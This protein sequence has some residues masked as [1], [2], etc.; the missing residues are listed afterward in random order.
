MSNRWSVRTRLTLQSVAVTAFVLFALNSVVY[1]R[2]RADLYRRIDQNLALRAEKLAGLVASGRTESVLA[3]R[4]LIQTLTIPLRPRVFDPERRSVTQFRGDYPFDPSAISRSLAGETV[5]TTCPWNAEEVRVVSRPLRRNDG[6]ITRAAQFAAPLTDTQQALNTLRWTLFAMIPLGLLASGGAGLFLTNRALQPV[7]QVTEAT[8][9]MSAAD[10]SERLPVVGSD[11]FAQ[12]SET[13]NGM[14]TRLE[15]T[16]VRQHQFTGDASH[17]LRT[18]LTIIT[19]NAKLT[20]KGERSP[21]EYRRALTA[22]EGAAQTMR[23]LVDDLLTLA[24]ADSGQ[25][26]QDKC[27]ID[28]GPL[29]Q[30]TVETMNGLADRAPIHVETSEKLFLLA[31]EDEIRRLFT[32]LLDNAGRHTPRTGRILLSAHATGGTIRVKVTDNGCGIAAEHLPHLFERFYRVDAARTG[33]QGTGI[34]LAICRSIVTAHQGE[35]AIE[36]D[37]AKGT[38]VTI[39][40][41]A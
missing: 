38:T 30:S 18:P 3:E 39:D 8:A 33:G 10:L 2:T 32:N 5:M 7:R 28:L 29:L 9:K 37:L 19:A 13:V 12:L 17:E 1:L 22:I 27:V 25:S 24:R 34:G 40:F 35:I 31:N 20:L 21:E 26:A 6:T 15:E 16:F 36:S 23:G 4:P 11:E 41:P 14:L